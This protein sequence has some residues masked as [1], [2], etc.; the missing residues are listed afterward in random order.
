M[1]MCSVGREMPRI[2]ERE[3]VGAPEIARAHRLSS[4][5]VKTPLPRQLLQGK[6][7][8]WGLAYRF[9]NIIHYLHDKEHGA[10]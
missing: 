7:F 2:K 3:G 8:N 9:R 5:P 10:S 1:D 4:I 6:A